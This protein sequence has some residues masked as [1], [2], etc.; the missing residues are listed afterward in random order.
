MPIPLSRR[1]HGVRPLTTEGHLHEAAL[2]GEL[3]RGSQQVRDYLGQA[4]AIPL[5]R[6]GHL[7]KARIGRLWQHV[8]RLDIAAEEL[9][10]RN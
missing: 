8:G 10:G 7:G 4:Q 9:E 2:G 6:Q 3:R 5:D 1:Q